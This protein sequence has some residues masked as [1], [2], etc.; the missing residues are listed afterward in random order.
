MRTELSH[1]EGRIFDLLHSNRARHINVGERRK[2]VI[3]LETM[4]DH[5]Y[6]RIPTPFQMEEVGSTLDFHELLA[7]SEIYHSYLLAMLQTHQVFGQSGEIVKHIGSV[8]HL[9]AKKQ[10]MRGDHDTPQQSRDNEVD[11]VPPDSW[12]KC[13]QVC[14]GCIN[15]CFNTCISNTVIR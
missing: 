8:S 2:R 14:R 10:N 5:W 6:G 11:I 13:V 12:T 15:L 4:L 1:I 3:E 9:F 7:M